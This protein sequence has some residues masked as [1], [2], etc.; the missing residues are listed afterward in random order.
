M[1]SSSDGCIIRGGDT[2]ES[3]GPVTV[4][5]PS[6]EAVLEEGPEIR[7]ALPGSVAFSSWPPCR[8]AAPFA[9]LCSDLVISAAFRFLFRSPLDLWQKPPVDP[10]VC[11]ERK[12]G[13]GGLQSRRTLL[14]SLRRPHFSGPPLRTPRE[15]VGE[16]SSICSSG[17]IRPGLR[18]RLR[19]ER[20]AQMAKERQCSSGPALSASSLTRCSSRKRGLKPASL[21]A[22][23]LRFW[24]SAASLWAPHPLRAEPARIPWPPRKL[25]GCGKSRRRALRNRSRSPQRVLRACVV[26]AP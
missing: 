6:D 12:R 19:M 5:S 22:P 24:P 8:C 11:R 3:F 25:E 13:R 16:S 18:H 20:L 4:I 15:R 26:R 1:S 10:H 21:L 14:I 2:S 17:A 9:G 23:K 7:G